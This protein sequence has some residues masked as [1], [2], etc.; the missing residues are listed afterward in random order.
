MHDLDKISSTTE[1]FEKWQQH[2]KDTEILMK[3]FFFNKKPVKIHSD[4]GSVGSVASVKTGSIDLTNHIHII[5][6]YVS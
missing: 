5:K 2:F 3:I 4:H 1:A 6:F